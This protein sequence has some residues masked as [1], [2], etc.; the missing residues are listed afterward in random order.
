[1][2][3][4]H[5]FQIVEPSHDLVELVPSEHGHR[6]LLSPSDQPIK[7][8]RVAWHFDTSFMTKVLADTWGVALADLEWRS[9]PL[10]HAAQWYFAA[11]DGISRAITVST[12]SPSA[13]IKTEP[14]L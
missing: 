14:S 8:V 2:L 6:I 11:Y 1:M 13:P 12:R 9:L 10:E 4:I 7:R 3:N 5:P